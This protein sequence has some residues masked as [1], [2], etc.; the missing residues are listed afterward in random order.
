MLKRP[1]VELIDELHRM[2]RQLGVLKRIYKTYENTVNRLLQ[3]Q[4]RMLRDRARSNG[5]SSAELNLLAADTDPELVPLVGASVGV[6]LSASAIV[7]FER[8]AD[9]IG[10]YVLGEIEDC[11][12]EKATLT[13]LVYLSFLLAGRCPDTDGSPEFQLNRPQRLPGGGKVN[14]NHGPPGQGDDDVFARELDDR[15]LLDGDP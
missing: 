1:K 5:N 11:L 3:H 9:R 7:R 12:N 2:G 13:F 8:L 6:R 10:L 14:T 4:Q 15:I